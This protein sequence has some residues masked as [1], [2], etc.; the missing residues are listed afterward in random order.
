MNWVL[1]KP[2]RQKILLSEEGCS[3]EGALLVEYFSV[4]L[5]DELET[6]VAA[7]KIQIVCSVD[8]GQA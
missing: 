3:A 7:C 5:V 6:K 4:Y 1:C 8:F 2:P